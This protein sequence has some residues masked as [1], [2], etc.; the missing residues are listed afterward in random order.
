MGGHEEELHGVIRQ[1]GYDQLLLAKDAKAADGMVSCVDSA[2]GE[3]K[4]V[5]PA[6]VECESG[7]ER[8]RSLLTNTH[9]KQAASAHQTKGD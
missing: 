3:S 8:I 9:S 5:G 2:V 6:Q 4:D 7:L 1:A